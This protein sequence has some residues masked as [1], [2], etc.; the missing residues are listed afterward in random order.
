V[1]FDLVVS[2]DLSR[3]RRTAEVM[4]DALG[5]DADLVVE[6]GLREYDV[7]EWSGCT[8]AEIEARW[9]GVLEQWNRGALSA[10]P[11]G[12]ARSALDARV[13]EA[14][15]RVATVAAE[16]GARR[17]LVVA[18]GGVIRALARANR[19][20]EQPIGHLAGYVGSHGAGRLLPE[21]YVDLLD[22]RTGLG[23]TDPDPQSL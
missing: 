18:H 8:R 11:G 1:T 10:P 19:R 7:G 5:L 16:H 23:D 9:P 3:A 20:P 15:S 17:I 14:G 12:E 2:S 6:P 21:E 4:S 22:G 13:V